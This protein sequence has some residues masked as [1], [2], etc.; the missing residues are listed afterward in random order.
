MSDQKKQQEL[1]QQLKNFSIKH[2]GKVTRR[3]YIADGGNY[4]FEKAFGSFSEFVKAAGLAGDS[5][6]PDMV[7][8]GSAT[9]QDI[10]E[11]KW[12][13][14]LPKTTINNYDQLKAEFKI[15]ESIW[16]VKRFN[17]TYDSKNEMYRVVAF[18]VK[19][20]NIV[21]AREELEALKA[22]KVGAVVREKT[23]GKKRMLEI[24]IPD[25]HFGKLSWYLETGHESYDTKIAEVVFWRALEA[26][27]K[28]SSGYEYDQILFVIG[29]DV[30]N[31]D[32]AE[33]HTTRGTQVSTDG[34]YHKTFLKVRKLMVQAIDRLRK[35]APVKV[36]VVS[37]NH[38][39]LAAWHL[40]DSLECWFDGYEDV[41]ID[42]RPIM[43]K[44]HQYGKCMLMLTHG[45]KGKREDYPLL[46]ATEQ[47]KMFG[48]TRFREAHTGHVH[49]TKTQEFHG[50]RVRIL[51]A[52]CPPDA[53]HAENGYVGNLR[54]AEA[55]VW[56]GDEGLVGQFFY[57]DD[58]QQT[59]M[60]E[61]TVQAL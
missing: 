18:L 22:E 37:G 50:V 46:M 35:I 20:E 56:D 24:N 34:R 4:E 49:Q 48:E 17:A 44:Y 30:L 51:S 47:A 15:D 39:T 2:P 16:A 53:W 61:R 41:E 54:S 14:T 55:Y 58:A 36:V 12:V 29:N 59:L 11:D 31:S 45:D 10:T 40:G 13:I 38:D 42:N 43:R 7:A 9:Q 60:T 1:I 21:A 23:D 33:S 19:K 8:P 52:L 28:R 26:L 32:D 25:T 27:L 57:N 5:D 6:V 3:A